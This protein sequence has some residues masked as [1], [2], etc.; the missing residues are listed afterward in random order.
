[1]ATALVTGGTS[2][3]GAAFARALAA[4]GTN[5]VL[6][7]RNT[8]RLAAMA[9]ELSERYAVQVETLA[10]DLANREDV[11]RVVARLTDA[12]RPVDLLV[13]NAGFGV[14]SRLTDEDTSAHEHAMDVMCR[15]VLILGAAAGRTM[16]ERGK[17][18]IINVSS[19]A[20]FVAMGSYSAIKAWVTAYSESLAVELAGTGVTV[21]AL[22]P[23]WVE[24]EF[25]QRA[26]INAGSIPRQL[27][28]DA[29]QLVADCLRDAA[30]G[31]VISI[32]SNRYKVL[33]TLARHAPRGAIRAVSRRLTSSRR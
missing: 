14:H 20:G 26:G 4:R 13:N 1:M 27:W 33:M 7:A 23:G 6:V 30:R 15:A 28:L 32:P 2:G 5:L 12:A 21:T 29:D 9:A 31:K 16:R 24:T 10:A 25:H 11:D 17:G 8:E 19:T 22:C 3:I 18:T